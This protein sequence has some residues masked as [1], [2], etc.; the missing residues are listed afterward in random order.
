MRGPI[1]VRYALHVGDDDPYALVE[2]AFVPLRTAGAGGGER[3]REGSALTVSGAPVSSLRR[4]AGR[5]EVRVFNPTA[6]PTIVRFEG[7]TGWLVDLRGRPVAPFEG[8]FE[9]A[10]WRIATARLDA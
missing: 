1:E 5:L 2:D 10:P 3:A 6:K 4:V 9:L 8:G 7:A